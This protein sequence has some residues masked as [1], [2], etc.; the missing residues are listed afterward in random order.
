MDH[1][2]TS[3]LRDNEDK[4]RF[5]KYVLGSRALVDRL[6]DIAKDLDEQLDSKE[7]AEDVYESPSWAYKQADNNGYRRCLRQFQ[8]LFTLDP[9]N[10]NG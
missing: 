1:K 4:E 2:W 7:I 10:L 5:K 6:S 3:H 9:R 8:K